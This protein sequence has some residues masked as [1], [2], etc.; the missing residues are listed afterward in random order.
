MHHKTVP[1]GRVL[2]LAGIFA[3]LALTLPG[4]ASAATRG[5]HVYNFSSYEL[6]LTKVTKTEFGR[7]A[8]DCDDCVESAPVVG[9]VLKPGEPYQDWEVVWNVSS[10]DKGA[11]AEYDVMDD[12][13]KVGTMNLSMDV[14]TYANDSYC[15]ITIG[16]C[17]AEGQTITVLDPAGTKHEIGPN[18]AAEQFHALKD[19]CSE[20]NLA[21]C[22]FTPTK[23]SPGPA[24]PTLRAPKH[25][26][27][28]AVA[29]CTEDPQRSKRT[30]EDNYVQTNSVEVAVGASFEI[31]FAIGKAGGSIK[32]TYG[33]EWTTEHK[34]SE[35]E[36]LDVRPGDLAWVTDEAPI[37]RDTGDYELK[38]G[39]TTWTLRGVY[40]DSPDPVG[41]GIFAKDARKLSPEEYAVECPHKEK[42]GLARA[43][44]SLVRLQSR[45]SGEPNLFLGGPEA[46]TMHGHNGN[47]VLRGGSGPDRLF[48]GRGNDI[49][50][51]GAGNDVLN[52]GPGNDRLNGGPGRDV[53]NGG[54]GDDTITDRRGPTIVR[55]GTNTARGWDRVN[56]QDGR[57][58][59][60]VICGSRRTI[61]R[62]DLGD[63]VK[64]HCGRVIRDRS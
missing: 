54:A 62:V 23:R 30:F 11:R 7:P 31:N 5:F 63:R 60:I 57:G 24:E 39:N 10:N 48:G 8:P 16:T 49:L 55:T 43:P 26:V 40:F 46:N 21:T 51:G 25:I 33:H 35:E 12:R 4:A 14:D 3:V 53:L 61:V 36:S 15:Q 32:T 58:D 1:V 41:E 2:A 27:G 38:L 28:H 50:V 42:S 18:K 20:S 6:K 44:L 17:K 19:L 52:G 37:I 64:G 13:V 22:T 47:D 45:G 59:D 34:F 29:N 56:V 9:S